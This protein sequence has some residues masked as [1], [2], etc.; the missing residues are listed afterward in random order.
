MIPYDICLSFSVW[1]TCLRKLNKSSFE[2]SVSLHIGRNWYSRFWKPCCQVVF[3]YTV[4]FI[5]RRT[6]RYYCSPW[7][8]GNWGSGSFKISLESTELRSGGKHGGGLVAKSCP[9]LVIPWTVAHKAPLSMGFSRKEYWS[10][11]PFPS[12]GDLSNPRIEPGSPALQADSLL[13]ELRGKPRWRAYLTLKPSLF[14][15]PSICGCF[16]ALQFVYL[17]ILSLFSGSIWRT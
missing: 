7:L 14:T 17:F 3:I 12:P 15:F 4:F 5:L 9:T 1:L 16:P 6:I 8:W 2:V 13:T 10:G 11:L